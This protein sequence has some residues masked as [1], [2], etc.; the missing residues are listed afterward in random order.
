MSPY[1]PAGSRRWWVTLTTDDKRYVRL[2]T[3]TADKQTAML[4][5]AM[6]HQISKQGKRHWDL[7]KYLDKNRDQLPRVFDHWTLGTMDEL[8]QEIAD[9]DLAPGLAEWER[10]ITRDLATETV[11]KYIGQVAVLFPR[12]E[13]VTPATWKPAMRSRILAGGFFIRQLEQVKGSGTNKARHFAAW[14]SAMRYLMARGDLL[15]N[16]LAELTQPR[17]NKLK[18]DELFIPGVLNVLKYLKAMPEGQHRAMA[19]LREGG[20]LE[21][22]SVLP[23]RRRDVTDARNRIVFAAGQKNRFRARQAIIDRFAWPY[24]WGFVKAGAFMPETRLFDVSERKHRKVHTEVCA[25]LRADGVPIP[26]D[27]TPHK[28]RRTYTVRHFRAGDD[29]KMIAENLGHKDERMI[30]ALY[31]RWR[32]KMVD[33]VRASRTAKGGSA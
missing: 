3:G 8:R 30:M 7:V 22:Q 26:L 25:K 18:D 12:D 33:I 2:K 23:M 1:K 17:S 5:Q 19:A 16:P 13:S 6:L 15:R 31:G 14:A 24:F 10:Q 4:M 27:Y 29:P 20:G 28:C 11:R 9:V 21:L 32:P